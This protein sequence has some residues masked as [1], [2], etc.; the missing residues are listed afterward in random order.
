MQTHAVAIADRDEALGTAVIERLIG[1]IE[2]ETFEQD[3]VGMVGGDERA[4]AGELQRRGT[5]GADETGSG[6]QLDGADAIAS[7]G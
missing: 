1:A 3:A 2:D 6:A 7:G 4:A 5:R